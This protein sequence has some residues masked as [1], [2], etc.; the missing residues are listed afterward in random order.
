[1]PDLLA[2]SLACLRSGRLIFVG[3]G[4]ALDPGDALLLVGPNGSGKSSLLRLVAGLVRPFAGRL[5]WRG[6]PVGED[7]DAWRREIAYVGHQPAV[8]PALTVEENLAFWAGYKDPREA[9]ARA[10]LA[11]DALGLGGLGDVP[12]RFLSA[13]QKQR[14]GLA[15][16]LAAPGRVWLLDEPGVGLDRDGVARLSGLIRTHRDQGGIVLAA[17]HGDVAVPDARTLSVEAFAPADPALGQDA[18]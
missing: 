18:P 6:R 14:V 4:F 7:P 11:G 10:L 5:V 2:E 1:M 13:G 12:G 17:T 16:L 3:L 15:R 9:R 8:K